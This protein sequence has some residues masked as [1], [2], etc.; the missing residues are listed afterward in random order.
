MTA[1]RC[2]LLEYQPE[3]GLCLDCKYR[4]FVCCS[5]ADWNREVGIWDSMLRGLICR[6][7]DEEGEGAT[8]GGGFSKS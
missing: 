8:Y 3:I 7:E 1:V 6:G 2:I 4:W 5:T